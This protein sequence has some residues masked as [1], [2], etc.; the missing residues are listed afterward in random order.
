[1]AAKWINPLH[2][3][4]SCDGKR[5]WDSALRNDAQAIARSGQLLVWQL[6]AE[7]EGYSGEQVLAGVGAALSC[8]DAESGV[9]QRFSVSG[10][11]D[12][13]LGFCRRFRGP[14][15]S[16][17][18]LVFARGDRVLAIRT[19]STTADAAAQQAELK[20]LAPTFVAAFDQD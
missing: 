19:D 2:L 18:A 20:R 14:R 13:Q 17:C 5:P 8:G 6:A 11:A 7:Y 3:A 1:M 15:M 4:P 9:P 10:V 16:S 12:P